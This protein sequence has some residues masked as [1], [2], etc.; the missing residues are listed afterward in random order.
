M[1][2]WTAASVSGTVTDEPWTTMTGGE[3]IVRV[4]VTPTVAFKGTVAAP[5]HSGDVIVSTAS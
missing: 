5:S 1:A 3:V 2:P 4:T